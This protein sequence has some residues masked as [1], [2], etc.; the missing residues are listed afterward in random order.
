MAQGGR[1]RCR[2]AGCGASPPARPSREALGSPTAHLVEDAEEGLLGQKR[3]Q[4]P[5]D[6]LPHRREAREGNRAFECQPTEERDSGGRAGIAREAP[7]VKSCGRGGRDK[8]EK[9][10]G[11]RGTGGTARA[12][13]AILGAGPG[14]TDKE[15]AGGCAW[16]SHLQP[17][18]L[19][20]HLEGAGRELGTVTPRKETVGLSGGLTHGIYRAG[21]YRRRAG[22]SLPTEELLGATRPRYQP[23]PTAKRDQPV[24]SQPRSPWQDPQG[25]P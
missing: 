8:R 10:G 6:D 9:R 20:R 15:L 17:R 5:D 23:A 4:T 13:G 19:R 21:I 11:G 12:S 25:L 3:G 16:P 14:P 2:H 1:R 24:S 7:C 18:L 22:V